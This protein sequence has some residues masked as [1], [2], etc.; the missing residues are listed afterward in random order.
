VSG[1]GF[2]EPKLVGDAESEHGLGERRPTF[3][4]AMYRHFQLT[5]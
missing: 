2:E 4:M 1:E 3:V 5:E